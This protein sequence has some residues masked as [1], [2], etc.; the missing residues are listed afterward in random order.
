MNISKLELKLNE[1]WNIQVIFIGVYLKLRLSTIHLI[2]V[3]V[4][5]NDQKGKVPCIFHC[6]LSPSGSWKRWGQT[7]VNHLAPFALSILLY[8]Q[9]P[10]PQNWRIYEVRPTEKDELGFDLCTRAAFT[11][12]D[13]HNTGYAKTGPIKRQFVTLVQVL[14]WEFFSK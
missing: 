13:L 14:F 3:F 5:G 7:V 9:K 1:F 11:T 2:S 6:H 10:T 4:Q 8:S 12:G